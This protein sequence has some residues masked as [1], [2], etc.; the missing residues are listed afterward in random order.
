MD[1]VTERSKL[2]VGTKL[3]LLFIS[4]KRVLTQDQVAL[5]SSS[6]LT[7]MLKFSKLRLQT[8]P[9]QI[10]CPRGFPENVRI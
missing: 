2:W 3:D 8:L 7:V 6:K 1:P 10:D 5:V 9:F 4:F